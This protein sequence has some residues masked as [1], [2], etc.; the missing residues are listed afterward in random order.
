MLKRNS[1]ILHSLGGCQK[2]G[3]AG[4]IGGFENVYNDFAKSPR[5]LSSS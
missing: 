5:V 1:I 4:R 2:R 3:P